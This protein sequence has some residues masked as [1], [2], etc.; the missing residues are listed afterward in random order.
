[1][2]P[3]T[4]S[5]GRKVLE[6]A[7]ALFLSVGLIVC[8]FIGYVAFKE[9]PKPNQGSE[10]EANSKAL[11]YVLDMLKEP[12]TAKFEFVQAKPR[13]TDPRIWDVAGY[14]DAQNS[15]G[16]MIRSRYVCVLSWDGLGFR[17]LDDTPCALLDQ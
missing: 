12:N 6:F 7:F 16:A 8:G 9:R 4:K 3:Q 10:S 2:R 5:T 14:V 17:G 13:T 1:M 11:S 15:F